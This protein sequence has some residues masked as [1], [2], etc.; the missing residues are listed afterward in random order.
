MLFRSDLRQ[1][2]LAGADLSRAN[3]T[4]ALLK[5]VDVKDAKRD[6]VRGL[7]AL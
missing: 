5:G 3:F 6:G 1:A 4:G 2:I 7:D